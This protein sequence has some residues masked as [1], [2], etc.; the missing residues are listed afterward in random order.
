MTLSN[1]LAYHASNLRSEVYLNLESRISIRL[2]DGALF[3][4]IAE[5]TSQLSWPGFDPA[6]HVEIT[7]SLINVLLDGRVKPGHDNGGRFATATAVFRFNCSVGSGL[8]CAQPGRS[9]V[10]RIAALGLKPR[11]DRHRDHVS[12]VTRALVL[13][14]ADPHVDGNGK[15]EL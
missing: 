11:I 1:R 7:T 2:R 13:H 5:M 3:I 6:I 4:E 9:P 14:G 10:G 8:R 12:V 15:P